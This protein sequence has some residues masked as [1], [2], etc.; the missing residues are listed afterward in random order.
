MDNRW[1]DVKLDVRGHLP[2]VPTLEEGDHSIWHERLIILPVLHRNLR[3]RRNRVLSRAGRQTDGVSR[4]DIGT[5][6]AGVYWR[7][8]RRGRAAL[9]EKRECRQREDDKK[10]AETCNQLHGN[11]NPFTAD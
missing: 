11:I 3:T 2:V 8:W 1:A 10:T 4:C 7:N 5:G 9:H 6:S